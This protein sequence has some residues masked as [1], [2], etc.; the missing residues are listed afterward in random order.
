MTYWS[1]ATL[2]WRAKEHGSGEANAAR[3]VS[4][5]AAFS[6]PSTSLPCQLRRWSLACT[7]SS[8]GRWP[9]ARSCCRTCRAHMRS[10]CSLA[11][12]GA[13]PAEHTQFV[14]WI[15]PRCPVAPRNRDRCDNTAARVNKP[16]STHRQRRPLPSQQTAAANALAV[17]VCAIAVRSDRLG[18]QRSQRPQSSKRP[19]AQGCR[20]GTEWNYERPGRIPSGPR[21]VKTPCRARCAANWLIF[22]MTVE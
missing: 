3:V 8:R 14:E 15:G 7:T 10:C 6:S 21:T 19:F 11:F 5:R 1:L 20:H 2:N 4:G 16:D 22:G 17:R 12:R 18:C 9:R 13:P